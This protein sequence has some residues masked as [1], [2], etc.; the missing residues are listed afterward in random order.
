MRRWNNNS[1]RVSFIIFRT[2][3]LNDYYY[4]RVCIIK[5]YASNGHVECERGNQQIFF[6]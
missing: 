5:L 3:N 4:V 6:F 2:I 1:L